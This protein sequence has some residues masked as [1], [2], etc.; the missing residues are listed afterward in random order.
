[1]K[2]LDIP[3]TKNYGPLIIW[4]NDL[5]DLFS[6]LKDYKNLEF[7]A[8]N[9]QFDSIEEFVQESRGRKPSVVKIKSYE[10]YL[11][12]ELFPSSAK[13]YVSSSQPLESGLFLK[14][15]LILSR[16]ER[17]PRF[18]FSS[19]GVVTSSLC[20]ASILY[21]LTSLI[22]NLTI[23]LLVLIFAITYVWLFYWMYI[24][25]WKFCI[26]HPI[27]RELLL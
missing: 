15:D 20:I 22:T 25:T 14:V 21:Y 10:P 1:M 12:I 2:K 17:K 26:V 23:W 16:C 8:D 24:R 9:V 6:E 7:V 27:R 19:A 4:A 3:R 11:I 13:L 18:F 5:F